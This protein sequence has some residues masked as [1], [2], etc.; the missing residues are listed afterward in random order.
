MQF[1]TYLDTFAGLE[2]T[3]FIPRAT[4]DVDLSPSG[5]MTV[6]TTGLAEVESSGK[7]PIPKCACG[8]L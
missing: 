1:E 4:V 5:Q 3:V 2:T 6:T 8:V 7:P